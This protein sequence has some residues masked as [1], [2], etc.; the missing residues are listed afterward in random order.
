M[1]SE[2]TV[3]ICINAP[4]QVQRVAAV[5]VRRAR[6]RRGDHGV[7]LLPAEGVRGA[8]PRGEQHGRGVAGV[9][10]ILGLGGG[11][12]R[13][14]AAICRHAVPTLTPLPAFMKI[15]RNDCDLLYIPEIL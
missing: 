15:Y 1:I 10:D 7:L 9:L 4:E 8:D 14:P 5:A 11:D 6:M 3:A 13:L 2:R 12:T